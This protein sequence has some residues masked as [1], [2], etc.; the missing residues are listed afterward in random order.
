MIKSIALDLDGT[1]LNSKK[2]ISKKNIDILRKIYEKGIEILIVTGR[3]YSA[4][5]SIIKKLDL[6]I[7]AICYNGAK[8]IDTKNEEILFEEPLSE[9]I[10]KILIKI[11]RENN[12]HL[13]L[14]Q[15]EEWF[16]ENKQNWQTQY[17]KENIGIDAI[18]INFDK[19]LNLLMTKALFVDERSNLEKV[20]KEIL[21]KIG[22]I[23]H[24][25][26]SQEKYLEV[27]NKKVNKGKSLERI[28]KI[29]N[30]T[31]ETCVAFGDANNDKEMIEMVG[32]G[33]AMGN[34][35]DN[36]KEI[37]KYKTSSNDNDGVYEFLVQKI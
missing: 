3:S 33:V 11:S 19:F 24:L 22:E 25:T 16:V 8:V 4:T 29:K 2:E 20:E 37:A 1:L 17:Y 30:L 32:Y 23:V 7:I 26:Y 31:L 9:E 21:E 36:L 27:L 28:L 14:Y 34:A 12:I 13:N 5:K 6:P 15:D 35:E 18:E 10:V